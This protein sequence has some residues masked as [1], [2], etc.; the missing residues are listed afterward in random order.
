MT[1]IEQGWSKKA[2]RVHS[3]EDDMLITQCSFTGAICMIVCLSVHPY[4][5]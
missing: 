1:L 3:D 5:V 4:D 2:A